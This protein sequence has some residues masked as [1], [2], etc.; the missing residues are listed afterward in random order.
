MITTV[1][2]IT[3]SG[4]K[5]E[6]KLC[7]NSEGIKGVFILLFILC[8]FIGISRLCFVILFLIPKDFAE[9]FCVFSSYWSLAKSFPYYKK[10]CSKILICS[11][12]LL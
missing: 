3:Y 6:V 8:E 12:E 9:I 2:K 5:L 11:E 1:S 4:P 10:I 7:L